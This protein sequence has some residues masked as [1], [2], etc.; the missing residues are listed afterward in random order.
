MF[1]VVDSSWD[2]VTQRE[3]PKLATVQPTLIEGGVR[4]DADGSGAIEV[5]RP[6]ENDVTATSLLDLPVQAGDAGDT[7]A[8]WI[9]ELLGEDCRLVGL[10]D[11]SDAHLPLGDLKIPLSWADAA[12]VLVANTASLDWLVERASE[13][14]EIA[15]FRPN[16][17]VDARAAWAED[18]WS[19]FTVG[20]A[21]ALIP[22]AWPRCVVPQIDQRSGARH[23]EPARILRQ[24]RWCASAPG[25][26]D[27]LR[28]FVE[29][30]ALFGIG[31]AIGPVGATV[32][33]GDE[34]IVNA[35]AEPIL[36]APSD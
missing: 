36:A 8:A 16:I 35:T 15:R 13:P 17:T 31:C 33:V 21:S 28:S 34:L 4:L 11:S 12:P 25:L 5:P 10:T 14:F 26:D 2:P 29:G 20:D 19:E 3:H 30:N 18:T 7:A 6:T 23:K 9:S 32:C 1:Q 27:T 24:H 22:L